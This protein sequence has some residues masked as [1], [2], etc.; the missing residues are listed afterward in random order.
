VKA[1]RVVL[2]QYIKQKRVLVVM[3]KIVIQEKFRKQTQVLLVSLIFD[4]F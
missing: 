1:V 2:G 3:K 4:S